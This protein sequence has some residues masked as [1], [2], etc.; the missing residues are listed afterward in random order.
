MYK[1][2]KRYVYGV[3]FPSV[4]YVLIS[5]KRGIKNVSKKRLQGQG[6]RPR[7]Y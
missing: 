1:K 6:Q 3:L 5:N 7:G 4:N 2:Y